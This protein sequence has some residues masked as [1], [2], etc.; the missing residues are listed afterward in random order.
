MK[1]LPGYDVA[2]HFTPRYN[3]WD[4]RVCAVP[5]G[6]LFDAI[7]GGRASMVTDHVDR[8]TPSGL[9]LRSGKELDADIIVTATGLQ[10][11]FLGGAE[12]YVD[13]QRVDLTRSISYKGSMFTDVPNLSW[14]FGYTNASWTLKAD[15]IAEYVCRL[16]KHMDAIGATHCT[17]RRYD[18]TLRE[19]PWVA[20]TSG[21]IER[22]IDQFPKQGSK[23]PFR[24]YQNYVIDLLTLRFGKL[25]DDAL[26]FGFAHVGR[27]KGPSARVPSPTTRTSRTSR[28]SIDFN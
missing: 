1:E 5:D 15:L 24:R 14:T 17:P 4:Q 8:F 27:K 2:T 18:P 3:V 23:R 20:F 10:M 21:Y 16:L 22:S 28:T 19:E 7:R 26:E 11:V 25:Q 6:D 9:R 12:V 13:G